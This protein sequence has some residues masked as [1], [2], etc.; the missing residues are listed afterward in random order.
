MPSVYAHITVDITDQ[1]GVIKL[2]RPSVLNAW[3]EDML[4][5]MISA[6]RELDQ[7]K[8]T[9]FT[10]LTGEGR[11]FSAGADIR[12][13]IPKAPE[14]ASPAEKKL[15][16]MRKFSREIELFRSLID[17]TKILVLALNGPGVGGGAAW[18]TGLADI[19]LA[20][21]GAYLQVPFNSL[22][23]VPEFGAA[24][25]FAQSIGVHRANDL[26][27]FGRKCT[28]EELESWGL[29]NRVFPAQGFMDQVMSFLR[30]QLEVNDGGSML[31]T[32]R[33]MN[34]PL[35]AERMLGTFDAANALA[36]RFVEGVPFER[37]A[38]RNE[39][40][41]M[42]RKARSGKEKASL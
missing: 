34:G 24:Q 5:E 20:V 40:L 32:K 4:G 35:R 41:K 33:L 15:F 42:A 3:N 38:R 27:M 21:S 18:F 26:L 14:T 10:V 8:R 9:V 1:V 36:E 30:G 19:V 11:F 2:N 23:L 39:E 16:Y 22:G 6:F 7:H 37:F 12:Q 17:H 29:I 13:D 31:E 25:T 28:V